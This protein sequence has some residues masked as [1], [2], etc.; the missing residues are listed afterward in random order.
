[1]EINKVIG[2]VLLALGLIMIGWTLWQSYN[3]FTDKASAPLIFKTQADQQA[4][5]GS[6]TDLQTQINQAIQKQLNQI[7]PQ[8][9]ITKILNLIAWSLLAWILITVGG[10]V[11]RIGVKLINGK[12]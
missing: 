3:I 7:L 8:A 6:N 12:S 2:Y 10:A 4:A 11:S 1:M 5:A 9:T